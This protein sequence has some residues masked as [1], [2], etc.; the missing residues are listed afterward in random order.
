[1]LA[2]AMLAVDE[3]LLV[4]LQL[5]FEQTT[6]NQCVIPLSNN[7]HEHHGGSNWFM[8]TCWHHSDPI[9]LIRHMPL[10]KV[11]ES[12]KEKLRRK[13]KKN[14]RQKWEGKMKDVILNLVASLKI[15]H[16]TQL[17]KAEQDCAEQLRLL[18]VELKGELRIVKGELRTVK[19]ELA[20]VK[21]R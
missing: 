19:D 17:E 3:C 8:N 11:I 6:N 10:W 13:R 4:R 16:T 1:M 2:L 5:I 18:R 7:V 9:R 20:T 15:A 21:L 14:M 12:M